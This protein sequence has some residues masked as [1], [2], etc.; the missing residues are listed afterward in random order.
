MGDE[1]D[2]RER[3]ETYLNDRRQQGKWYESLN[4]YAEAMSVY[5]A[6]KDTENINRLQQKMKE[7]YGK[8]AGKLEK[9]GEIQ[10]AANLYYL[11]GD[12]VSV[13]RLK[14]VKPDLVIIYDREGEGLSKIAADLETGKDAADPNIF[15]SKQNISGDFE[16]KIDEHGDVVD[17][18]ER[19]PD[20]P[21]NVKKEVVGSK[22]LPVKMPKNKK[23]MRFCPYCGE[24]IN[25]KKEPK[26]CPF[27]G[28]ELA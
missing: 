21:D 22:E 19:T 9:I 7:E 15:F 2:L 6:I 8:Q 11:I 14:K 20:R 23:K 16:M 4:L 10:Q 27:C 13:G 12:H 1:K 25:T 18:E 17:E 28:D 24:R 3:Q 5:R 26:F